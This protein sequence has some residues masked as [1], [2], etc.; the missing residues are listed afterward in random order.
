MLIDDLREA[1]IRD[2]YYEI[3]D[4]TVFKI[5]E[6][7]DVFTGEKFRPKFLPLPSLL[8][9]NNLVFDF[10][11]STFWLTSG[12]A[13][14]RPTDLIIRAT[15]FDKKIPFKGL[16]GKMPVIE[17]FLEFDENLLMGWFGLYLPGAD[18]VE[19]FEEKE[20]FPPFLKIYSIVYKFTS[21]LACKNIRTELTTPPEK[22][23]AKRRKKGKLP[24][25][26][27]YTLKLQ[28]P[29]K[30]SSGQAG[31]GAWTNRV[32]LC[33]GHMRE[34]TAESPLFGRLVGRYW[35][36]PHAR[37]NKNQGMIVKDYELPVDTGT[38]SSAPYNPRPKLIERAF[39]GLSN[40]FQGRES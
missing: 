24:L 9:F 30:K 12:K 16:A 1:G 7:V 19:Y 14:D 5:D 35:I 20:K 18:K 21:F 31:A 4:S 34:Y 40:K 13:E 37:G 27:Y 38:V 25:V 3:K 2:R 39:E 17:M 6:D 26:S 8:P 29:T 11:A 33:R 36:P 32:H 15:F 10:R 28:I 23:Q 22:V